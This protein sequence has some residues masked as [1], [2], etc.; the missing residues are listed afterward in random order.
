MNV[1][2]AAMNAT[3]R[4]SQPA[5]PT[6][7]STAAGTRPSSTLVATMN[8]TGSTPMTA[9]PTASSNATPPA[10]GIRAAIRHRDAATS[11]S[12]SR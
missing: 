4:A 2:A 9:L 3:T 7:P 8:S 1:A 6:P 5:E 11:S 10:R 12:V